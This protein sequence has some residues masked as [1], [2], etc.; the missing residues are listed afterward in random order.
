M[1][2]LTPLRIKAKRLKRTPNNPELGWISKQTVDPVLQAMFEL[3]YT[4]WHEEKRSTLNA[5]ADRLL[6]SY[7][8][9]YPQAEAQDGTLS[10]ARR[11]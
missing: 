9:T 7:R 6:A 8:T 4:E 11:D 2:I 10:G 5:Y 1:C 3:G